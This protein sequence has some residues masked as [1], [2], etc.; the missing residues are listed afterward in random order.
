MSRR[1]LA[2][3]V[4]GG[5]PLAALAQDVYPARAITIM[6]PAAPGIAPDPVA[7]PIAAGLEHVLSHPVAVSNKPA[8][9][10]ARDEPIRGRERYRG[11][12]EHQPRSAV[13]RQHDRL[14]ALQ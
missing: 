1:I 3:L 10:D 4:I 8:A 13:A 5:M 14:V 11:V 12:E 2:A 7:R 6:V 9:A